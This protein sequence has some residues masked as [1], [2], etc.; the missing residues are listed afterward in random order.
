MKKITYFMFYGVG[1]TAATCGGL[2]IIGSVMTDGD[3]RIAS[4]TMIIIK[5]II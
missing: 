5:R 4:I 2:G 1:C 3:A